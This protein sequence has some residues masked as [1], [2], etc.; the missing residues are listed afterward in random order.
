MLPVRLDYADLADQGMSCL[1]GRT[2]Y[3]DSV[4]DEWLV[5]YILREL[6]KQ[7]SDVWIK[8]VDKDGEFLLIEAANALPRWLNPEIADNRVSSRNEISV[9]VQWLIR[10]QVWINDGRLLL[11]PFQQSNRTTEPLARALTL[12]EAYS[13]VGGSRSTLVHLAPVEAEAFYRLRNYPNQIGESLHHTSATLPRKLAYILHE[14]PAYISPAVEAF[15]LRDPIA[16]RPLQ[17]QNPLKLAFP[18]EDLVTVQVKLAK[19][20]HAQLKGQQFSTPP[21]WRNILSVQ[22]SPKAIAQAEMGMRLTSGFEMLL[23]D[24]QHRDKRSV[25]EIRVLLHDVEHGEAQFPSDSDIASWDFRE[26]DESWLDINYEDFESEL[27]G[28]ARKNTSTVGGGFGDKSAH[29]NLRKIVARFEDFLNDDAAGPDGAGYLDDMDSDDD[30]DN[31]NRDNEDDKDETSEFSGDDEDQEVSFKEAEFTEMMREM[32]GNLDPDP[33]ANPNLAPRVRCI[34]AGKKDLASIK[35]IAQHVPDDM[36]QRTTTDEGEERNE[37][38]GDPEGEEIRRVM[39][40]IEA[41]LR[42][43]GALSLDPQPSEPAVGRHAPKGAQSEHCSSDRGEFE[44]IDDDL[45]DVSIDYNLARNL[46]ESFK[47]Q[48]GMAGPGG[49]ILRSMGLQLPRDEDVDS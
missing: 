13:Y 47:S 26:D 25:R 8:T 23:A 31:D 24:P 37:V 19:V 33:S 39:K 45:Q 16:L 44:R 35:S 36:R 28:N 10:E 7:H 43:A 2:N 40:D 14:S 17:T 38:H 41:E 1:R 3:G 9:Q 21:T 29:E 49:N 18:P 27:A 5:V 46:L 22:E 4:E 20:G 15:Y 42:D 11:I 6:S 12:Q 32:M 34:P 30:E 48:A